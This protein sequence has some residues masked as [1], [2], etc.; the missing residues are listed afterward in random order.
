MPPS[1]NRIELD[2]DEI[3]VTLS[4][5]GEG[6]EVLASGTWRPLVNIRFHPS[7]ERYVRYALGN[8]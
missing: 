2:G 6:E 7:R 3:Q 5:P 1:Y 8:P 4:Y